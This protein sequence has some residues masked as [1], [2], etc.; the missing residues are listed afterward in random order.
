MAD[1]ATAAA[2]AAASAAAKGDSGGLPQFDVS[3]WPGQMVWVLI[4]FAVL[5]V[6]FSRVFVPAVGG[7][8]DA[9][10]DRISGDI[11]DA[12]RARDAARAELETAAGELA[13]ARARA[14]KLAL[15]AQSEAKATAA[16][17]QAE[18]EARL[19]E[20]LVAAEARIAEARGEAMGHV[21]AIAIETAQA[22]I[23]R[24]TGVGAEA[25]EVERALV[26]ALP[27]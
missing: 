18:E 27:S 19:A 17:R 16:A 6:L 11:G 5:Y 10:E 14:Q 24:L 12:R 21:R 13:A 15:D 22:I 3:Q 9:R 4:I 25:A 2:A 20:T 7:T 23:T 1:P 26:D 8:I